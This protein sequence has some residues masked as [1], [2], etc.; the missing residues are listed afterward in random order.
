MDIDITNTDGVYCHECN[1]YHAAWYGVYTADSK[2]VALLSVVWFFFFFFL[3][4]LPNLPID[5]NLLV[6]F[7]R[8]Q[9]TISF[10]DFYSNASLENSDS[11]KTI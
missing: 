4:P 1:D 6:K 11:I 5:D 7:Q 2:T 10:F 9:N 8:N 3:L